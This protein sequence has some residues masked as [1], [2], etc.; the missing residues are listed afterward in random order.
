MKTCFYLLTAVFV[1]I[2]SL[3]LWANN[4]Q[5]GPTTITG[6]D[7]ASDYAMVQF[8]LSWDNS[9]RD[10]VNWDAAWV[11]V[12]YQQTGDD[13]KH[14]S[15]N[16]SSSNHDTPLGYTCSV[17]LTGGIGMGIFI[18]RNVNGSGNISLNNVRL[19]WEYGIDGVADG[20]PVKVQVFAVE[21]VY[22]PTGAF[23]A[24]SG[25]SEWS[26]FTLTTINTANATTPPTGTGGF[27]GSAQGGYPTGQTAP[28][29]ASWPNGYSAFYCMKYEISQGQYADFLN[30]LTTTQ[31]GNRFPNQN[32]TRRHTISGSQGSRSAGVPDRACNYLSWMGCCAYADW[33]GLRPMTELEYE[34]A[35]RGT[36]SPVANEYAWGNTSIATTAYT[37]SNDGTPSAV[38]TNA[39]SDPT[40]NASY[41]T[42][43]GS[44]DGPLRC[45]IFATSGSSRAEAGATYYGIMEMSGNLSERSVSIGSADGRTYTGT[46]GDGTLSTD[47]NAT[48]S[49][50]P[51]YTGSEVTNANGSGHRGGFWEYSTNYMR[52]SDRFSGHSSSTT[53]G[54][55]IIGFRCI[56][57]VF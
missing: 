19:R 14:A 8:D 6:V 33:A 9:F 17:G 23:A 31:D 39:A 25:G 48:N 15:L 29:N 49:D 43:D 53:R 54:D 13:W 3:S 42:T 22:V 12:K 44:I 34:K 18:Y 7:A 56:R 51:G 57:S 27:S 32:G 41:E 4:I 20:A 47:G 52:V 45:G 35:C 28:D 21:M 10:D 24:G 55:G 46:H 50:W 16:T 37:L 30:T 1:F 11:F 36:L 26:C 5:V 2:C 40:G 38:V